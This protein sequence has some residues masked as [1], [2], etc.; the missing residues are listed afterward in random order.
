MRI[1][2]ISFRFSL[3]TASANRFVPLVAIDVC[4]L[5][6][7]NFHEIELVLDSCVVFEVGGT[8]TVLTAYWMKWFFPSLHVYPLQLLAQRLIAIKNKYMYTHLLSVVSSITARLATAL[9]A[10]T[11]YLLKFSFRIHWG[12]SKYVCV[13]LRSIENTKSE[14]RITRKFVAK[15]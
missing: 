6:V 1:I 11:S 10:I 7:V 4:V 2:L 9:D 5:C 14:D 15:H 12:L 8:R 13:L 3:C